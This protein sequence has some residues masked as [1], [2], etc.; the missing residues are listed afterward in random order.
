[1]VAMSV[2]MKKADDTDSAKGDGVFQNFYFWTF[3]FF[4]ALHSIS[5]H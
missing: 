2:L 3:Y 5:F 4:A 1:M